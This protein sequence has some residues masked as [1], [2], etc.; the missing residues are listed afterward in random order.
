MERVEWVHL[1]LRWWPANA[2]AAHCSGTT[3]W[4]FALPGGRQGTDRAMQ[5]PALW[6]ERMSRWAV[7]RVDLV[8][9]LFSVL[10]RRRDVSQTQDRRYGK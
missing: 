5:Y 6:R 2:D 1:Q 3:E 8:G 4:W 10:R 9:A 7:G